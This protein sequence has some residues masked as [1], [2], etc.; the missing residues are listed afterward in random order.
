MNKGLRKYIATFDYFDKALMA[1]P[2]TSGG[3]SVAFFATIN[4]A[5]VGTASAV[6]SFAFSITIGLIKKLFKTT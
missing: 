1:L 6:V 2:A 5:P 3:V 4:C